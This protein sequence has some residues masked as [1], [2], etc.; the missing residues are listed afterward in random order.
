MLAVTVL[1]GVREAGVGVG[2]PRRESAADLTAQVAEGTELEARLERA[3]IPTRRAHEINCASER[4][5]AVAQGIGPAPHLDVAGR[6]RFDGLHVHATIG[7]IQRHTVLEDLQAPTVKG[8]LQAGSPNGNAGLLGA[9]ARLDID[10]GGEIEG[11]PE[12][13]SAALTDRFAFDERGAAGHLGQGGR[14]GGHRRHGKSGFGLPL[15]QHLGQASGFGGLEHGSSQDGGDTGRNGN[16]GKGTIHGTILR[17][18]AVEFPD[19]IPGNEPH[20]AGIGVQP[21]SSGEGTANPR[22]RGSDPTATLTGSR[23]GIEAR[24][25][26]G[27]GTRPETPGLSRDQA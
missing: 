22:N 21:T 7:Q 13:G 27:P 8:P 26:E 4:G 9:E 1:D 24:S 20:P 12:G 17:T 15:D 11:V 2:G 6:Q 10:A 19:G 5:A 25:E 18:I 14:G 23:I 16:G 3:G